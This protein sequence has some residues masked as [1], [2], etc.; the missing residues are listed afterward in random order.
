[1][2]FL[3]TYGNPPGWLSLVADTE[4]TPLFS[5]NAPLPEYVLFRLSVIRRD[6]TRKPPSRTFPPPVGIAH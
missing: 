1:M 6:W 5:T 4:D 2:T 3:R